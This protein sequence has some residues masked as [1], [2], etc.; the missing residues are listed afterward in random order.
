MEK[1]SEKL[2]LSYLILAV[3]PFLPYAVQYGMV[4]VKLYPIQGSTNIIIELQFDLCN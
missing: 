3:G 4:K 2:F 1:F